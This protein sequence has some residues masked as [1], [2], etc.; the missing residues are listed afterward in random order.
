MKQLEYVRRPMTM[1]TVIKCAACGKK[2]VFRM[3]RKREY[4]AVECAC[5]AVMHTPA[6][7]FSVRAVPVY[8]RRRIVA[9]SR[10]KADTYKSN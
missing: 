4:A 1:I 2:H 6:N 10:N 5:G 8:G 9:L 3:N 7:Q